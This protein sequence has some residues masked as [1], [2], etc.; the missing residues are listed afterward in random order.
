MYTPPAFRIEDGAEIAA[1]IRAARL[2]ILVSTGVDGQPMATHLPLLL[3]EDGTL[4]EGHLARANPQWR[5]L[6]RA[7]AIFPGP[8]AYVSPSWYPSKREHG[9]VVPTWNY[10]AV[11]AE[12]QVELVEEPAALHALVDRL[13]RAHEA[14]RPEPWAVD[15]APPDFVAAQLKGIVGLRLRIERVVAKKKMSQNRGEAD[16]AGVA[17]GLAADGEAAAAL[18]QPPG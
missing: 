17:A 4:I 7:L 12:G 16:R 5:G 8:E 9:R 13:T 1:W 10:V 18:V 3:S 6:T 2:A 11:H 14:P 15:D